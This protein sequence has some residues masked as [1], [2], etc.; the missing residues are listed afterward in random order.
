MQLIC[1]RCATPLEEGAQFCDGCGER[2][3]SSSEEMPRAEEATE[4]S[5]GSRRI[6]RRELLRLGA[7]AGAVGAGEPARPIGCS[8]AKSWTRRFGHRGQA[9]GQASGSRPMVPY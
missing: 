2:I 5:T 4:P 1:P 8:P 7:V 9:Q 6:S 3:A